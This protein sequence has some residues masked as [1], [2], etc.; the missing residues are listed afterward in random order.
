MKDPRTFS[1]IVKLFIDL[2]DFT[3][4]FLVALALLAFFKGLV[5]FIAKS[6]DAKNHEEGRDL[7][8]WGLVGLFAMISVFGIL[9][10]LLDDFGFTAW[11]NFLPLLPTG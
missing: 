4:P 8:V 1:D 6:G 7:M 9:R 10:L 3:L 11:T 5:A 2:I